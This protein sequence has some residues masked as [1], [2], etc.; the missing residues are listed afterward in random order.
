MS[1]AVPMGSGFL[2]LDKVK[3]E[4]L[5]IKEEKKLR[6]EMI[7][8]QKQSLVE[9]LQGVRIESLLEEKLGLQ[10]NCKESNG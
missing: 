4:I 1:G 6:E 9:L 7:E 8:E 3:R 2:L 10:K 5:K